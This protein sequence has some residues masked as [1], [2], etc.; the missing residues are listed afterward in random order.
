VLLKG[1]GGET[2]VTGLSRDIAIDV[3]LLSA[4]LDE[5]GGQQ[6]GSLT[7]G[8]PGDEAV[9]A[10]VLSFL[11]QHRFSVEHLGYVA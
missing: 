4:R 8:V 11:S 3:A 5:V 2:L 6:I 10:R 1:N 9:V 7:L